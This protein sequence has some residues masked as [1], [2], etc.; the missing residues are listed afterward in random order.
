MTS[1]SCFQLPQLW[2]VP[3]PL[4]AEGSDQPSPGVVVRAPVLE[5]PDM[6]LDLAATSFQQFDKLPLW[7][8]SFFPVFPLPLQPARLQ[9]SLCFCW[10]APKDDAACVPLER[11]PSSR[12]LG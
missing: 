6:D 12:P 8:C 3:F 9:S 11:V 7:S 10:T 5:A 1:R 2:L 4:S